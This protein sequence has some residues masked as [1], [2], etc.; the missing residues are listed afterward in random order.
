VVGHEGGAATQ[1]CFDEVPAGV[2]PLYF[3][4]HAPVASQEEEDRG[5]SAEIHVKA[6]VAEPLGA[7]LR[8]HLGSEKPTC[9]VVDGYVPALVMSR[10]EP[11]EA[12][13]QAAYAEA[14]RSMPPEQTE[15]RPSA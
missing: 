7:V 5:S 4:L 3:F 9:L 6:E 1:A 14:W 11:Y 2:A 12:P 10:R 15:Q 13:V 8:G